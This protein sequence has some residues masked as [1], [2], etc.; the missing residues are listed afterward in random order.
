MKKNRGRVANEAD[1]VALPIHD[2]RLFGDK[3][4]FSG[5]EKH[6][7]VLLE[8]LR[9]RSPRFWNKWRQQ[10]PQVVPD[11]RGVVLA[12]RSLRELNLARARLDGARFGR[13]DLSGAHLERASLK[14]ARLRFA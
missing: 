4:V 6:L 14:G 8:S 3:K 7:A 12:G 11:L 13:A 1:S 10:N 5:N 2:P 9:R